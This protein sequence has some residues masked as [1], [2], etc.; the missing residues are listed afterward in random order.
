[1]P[2]DFSQ[3]QQKLVE[4]LQ[5]AIADKIPDSSEVDGQQS[6]KFQEA[7]PGPAKSD[8][9]APSGSAPRTSATAENVPLDQSQASTPGDRILD[10]LASMS[11]QAHRID[12]VGA[13]AAAEGGDAGNALHAQI[14]MAK[15]AGTAGTA[16]D[17]VNKSSQSTDTLLKS[18]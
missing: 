9:D 10:H 4:K 1:M 16:T 18:S 5:S 15:I 17:A 8:V 11:K 14:E 6:A 12:Q 3:V 7:L 13:K 2:I